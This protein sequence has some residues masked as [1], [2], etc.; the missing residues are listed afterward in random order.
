MQVE[1]R[2]KPRFHFL[3]K[4][5]LAI[6]FAVKATNPPWVKRSI[7]LSS[8]NLNILIFNVR[9]LHDADQALKHHNHGF[10]TGEECGR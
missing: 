5:R 3:Q 4:L 2:C 1:I 7:E 6:C 10:Q 8:A 9:E